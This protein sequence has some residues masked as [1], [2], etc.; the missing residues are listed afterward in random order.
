MEKHEWGWGGRREPSLMVFS[1]SRSEWLERTTHLKTWMPAAWHFNCRVPWKVHL[2]SEQEHIS[3]FCG[4]SGIMGWM[5]YMDERKC[6]CSLCME[7]FR[8]MYL[9][10]CLFTLRKVLIIL[11]DGHLHGPRVSW[12]QTIPSAG[13]IRM[14]HHK[15]EKKNESSC[16]PHY[17]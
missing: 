6:S 5:P 10:P 1:R 11:L 17:Y 13:I 4:P 2:F 8:T 16:W 7:E 12:T 9:F 14:S 3:N 15:K